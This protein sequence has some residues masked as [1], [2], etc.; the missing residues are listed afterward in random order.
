MAQDAAH[1]TNSLNLSVDP[2]NATDSDRVLCQATLRSIAVPSDFPMS[3]DKPIKSPTESAAQGSQPPKLQEDPPVVVFGESPGWWPERYVQAPLPG[4]GSQLLSMLREPAYGAQR[5]FDLFTLMAITLAFGLLFGAMKA[6]NALP[7]VFFGVTSFVTF[8]GI[9]QMLLFKGNSPRLAS[10][11]GGP[12]ALVLT[13][14]L[15]NL[16]F[17]RM[18]SWSIFCALIAGAPFGYLAGGMVAGVFLIADMLREKFSRP[19]KDSEA[20]LWED[21]DA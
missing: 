14:V 8:I 20:S 17:G 18:E 3:V 5:V 4:P 6:L 10:V 7:E 2:S 11:V 15:L 1:L 12:V 16:W 13:A 9:G 21:K 19:P